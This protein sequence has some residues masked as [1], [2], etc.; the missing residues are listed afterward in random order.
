MKK[1]L[2]LFIFSSNALAFNQDEA[3][4]DSFTIAICEVNAK[5][6]KAYAHWIGHVRAI[7]NNEVKAHPL[8]KDKIE[9][10]YKE[11]KQKETDLIFNQ[12]RG[13][14]K[15]KDEGAMNSLIRNIQDLVMNN[16]E[17]LGEL[18][19]DMS[20]SY[21]YRKLEEGCNVDISQMKKM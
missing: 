9:S 2:I 15:P 16:A 12:M 13:T 19:P 7:A 5:A 20:E 8:D 14:L 21:Y 1:F 6:L 10:Q 3:N 4:V 17:I 11:I 18:Y